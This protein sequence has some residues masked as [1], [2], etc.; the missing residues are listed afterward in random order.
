MAFV[1]VKRETGVSP[2][3]TRHRN[4]GAEPMYHW[5]TGK[6]ANARSF[7]SGDLPDCV[8]KRLFRTTSNW[9][10]R[11]ER[12]QSNLAFFCFVC[13]PFTA[14]VEGFLMEESFGREETE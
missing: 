8:Q 6:M 2:V 11:E 9:L 7:E 4:K 10:Y 5:E 12:R 1:P 13:K 14:M 3:R